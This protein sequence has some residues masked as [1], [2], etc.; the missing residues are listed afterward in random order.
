MGWR[1]RGQRVDLRG[2]PVESGHRLVI[3]VSDLGPRLVAGH[4]RPTGLPVLRIGLSVA[5]IEVGGLDAEGPVAQV[6]DLLPRLPG[7]LAVPR[8][9][10][11]DHAG[12][13]SSD[14]SVTSSSQPPAPDQAR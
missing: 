1:S 10:V 14:R 7:H 5:V 9:L 8:L 3:P 2:F 6:V 11:G 12:V 13:P 4:L